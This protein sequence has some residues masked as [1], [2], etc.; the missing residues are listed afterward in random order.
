[1]RTTLLFLLPAALLGGCG[2]NLPAPMLSAPSRT[3]NASVSTVQPVDAPVVYE[4]TGNV[5]ARLNAT[6]SSKVMARVFA[7]SAREGDHVTAGQTLVTLDAREL[8]AG[9]EVARANLSASSVG[10]DSAR[11]ARDMEVRTSVARIAQARAALQQSQAASNAAHSKLDLALAGPRTQEKTQVHL[12]VVQ[13]ESSLKLAK[14]Q[15]DRISN[16]VGQG[17]MPQRDLD[18]AQNA[19][20][21]ALA[22][23]DTAV[24]TEKIAQEG[25]RSQDLQA[26]RDAVAQAK[27]AVKQA[28]ANLAQANASALQAK[29]R[30]EEIR[31]AQAQ[32]SQSRA[33][34]DSAEVTLGY[35]TVSAPFDGWIVRRSVDPGSMATPGSPLVTIEGGDLRLEAVVPE[36]VLPHI[37]L[38]DA[39]RV[40]LDAL[41]RDFQ[42]TVSEILPQGDASTHSFVVK[43]TLRDGPAIKSGMFGRA[44]FLTG[45]EKR[46]E[47]PT[48][49][50][51]EREG[52]HYVY[53]V[54][55]EGIARLRIVT[56]GV[57]DGDRVV[58]LSGL[59]PGDRIVTSHVDRVSDGAKVVK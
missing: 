39:V 32:V 51:W 12:A 27:A 59:S 40:R 20:D 2:S 56:L 10:V 57:A 41:N 53:A 18:L 29:I 44:F 6:L 35:S 55:A 49:A 5:K 11:T 13:A 48:Q 31:S 58:I 33:A 25:T 52:L 42:G 16:L 17:A 24:Q 21:V 36:S 1:M 22:Q 28:E 54:N 34:L 43:L 38:A 19:Y 23:R 9:V 15:L 8:A 14:T 46:I 50:T 47:V 37:H 26:A 4:A 45:R 7:V 3:V 30:A